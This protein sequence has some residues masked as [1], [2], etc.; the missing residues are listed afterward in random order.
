MWC[1]YCYKTIKALI[2]IH[3]KNISITCTAKI[4]KRIWNLYT[5]SRFT[6]YWVSWLFF[7]DS[8]FKEISMVTWSVL[9]WNSSLR[10]WDLVVSRSL[11]NIYCFKIYRENII[12]H[13]QLT[14]CFN[15]WVD[16]CRLVVRISLIYVTILF[17]LI[18]QIPEPRFRPTIL[19]WA[20]NL[21][22]I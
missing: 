5:Y 11:I 4:Y 18:C 20:K 22:P 2:I 7:Y 19:I 14:S 9:P 6:T 8:F 17:S 1:I 15:E 16:F 3:M 10:F 21:L 13:I 12:H